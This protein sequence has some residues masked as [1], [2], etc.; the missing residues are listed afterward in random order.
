M[1]GQRF[2]AFDRPVPRAVS[3]LVEDRPSEVGDVVQRDDVE[4]GGNKNGPTTAPAA[5]G[6]T[7]D[8]KWWKVW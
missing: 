5:V 1:R 7:K 6:D 2:A 4:T 8:G 3:P